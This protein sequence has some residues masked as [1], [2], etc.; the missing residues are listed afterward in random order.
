MRS[1]EA[2][3]AVGLEYARL[4]IVD[5][6]H[7]YLN[8]A[9][10]VAPRDAATYDAL[11]RLWRDSGFPHLGLGDAHRA[12]Y[13]AP[14]SPV[15]HNTLG[16]LLQALGKRA[17][18]RRSYERALQ[19][20]PGA[21]YAL[22][23]ICYGWMLDG[24]ASRAIAACEQALKLEPTLAA[25]RNNLGLAFAASGDV[26]AARAAFSQAANPAVA[27][28]N[29]G[30]VQLARRRYAEALESFRAAATAQPALRGTQARIRQVEQLSRPG[31]NE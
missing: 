28:Y 20:D 18:A 23:N 30:I 17:D 3:R 13:F 4:G 7:E 29:T 22:N 24:E 2:L 21:A 26:T 14:A 6:A 27:H 8:K 9:L 31:A 5:R 1:A 25:A 11:A 12:H 19:L 16:T 15:V 10:T